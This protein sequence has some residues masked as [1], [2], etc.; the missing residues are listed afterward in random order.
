[1]PP[2]IRYFLALALSLRGAVAALSV[3]RELP[4]RDA[5]PLVSGALLLLLIL[6]AAAGFAPAWRALGAAVIVAMAGTSVVL[7]VGTPSGAITWPLSPI[8]AALLSAPLAWRISRREVHRAPVPEPVIVEPR[9]ATPAAH[10]E[11]A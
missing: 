9:P 11:C 10:E 4:Y 3:I 7:L 5:G 6:V 2:T 8:Y 1:M